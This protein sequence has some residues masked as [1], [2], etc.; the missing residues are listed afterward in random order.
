[1]QYAKV[2][3]ARRALAVL[4]LAAVVA[5]GATVRQ[6]V[7]SAQDPGGKPVPA[8]KKHAKGLSEVFRAASEKIVP[9]VVTIETRTKP[10]PIENHRQHGHGDMHQE[11]PFKGTPF[12]DF[13]KDNPSFGFRMPGEGGGRQFTPRHEGTGS[14]V[15]IDKSGLILTNNHVV[16]GAD[17]VTVRL[18]DGREFK[19]TDIRTDPQSDLAVVHIKGAGSLPVA[20]L[21]DSSKMD[22]GD[23]VIAVGNPFGLDSTVSAGII[24]GKGRELGSN[25]RTRFLQTDAA[26][27]PGNSGGPL[28]DLDGDVI[29]INT[30][31]A[32]SSGGYQGIGFAIPSNLAKWVVHELVENGKVRRA[33]LGVAIEPVNTELAEK[34][35]TERGQG[36]LVAE[37]FPHSP[38]ADAGF[39]EGDIITGFAG[40]TVKTPRDLQEVVEQAEMNSTQT[41]KV[42]RDGKT[43]SLEVVVKALPNDFGKMARNSEEKSDDHGDSGYM[44]D[45]LG[46]EVTNMTP[47]QAQSLGYK[48]YKGVLIS[49]VKA[50]G[51]A[52][53]AGL[54]EGMLVLKVGKKPVESVE[55]FRAVMKDQHL[56]DG[57]LLLVRTESGNRFVVLQKTE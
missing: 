41:V 39:K 10:Q 34:F 24:S 7:T 47:E 13:F 40:T 48:T 4:G 57:I 35:H 43:M 38:A 54:R 12:E 46:M 44:S 21:G 36:V 29:G 51:L 16:E 22:I 31:I 18:H 27:N 49:D 25:K 53:E 33:Y 1:M 55:Q 14:G 30:A 17:E 2:S 3:P 28:V 50:D 52:S 32:T 20:K 8:E 19:G 11:N 23:W 45:E 9:A 5:I 26:I 15:I 56:K 42:L 37:V 6:Q